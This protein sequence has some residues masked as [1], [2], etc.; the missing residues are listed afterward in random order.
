MFSHREWSR[1]RYAENPD[2]REKRRASQRA[3]RESH[4]QELSE[5]R[6][7][8]RQTDPAYREKQ[9]AREREWRSKK[10]FK[11]VYGISLEDYHV[12]SARQRGACAICKRTSH[13]RLSVDHCHATG[14]VR[15]LL[16]RKCNSG[17]AF[18]EDD[19]TRLLAAIAYLQASRREQTPQP[20]G[21]DMATDNIPFDGGKADKLMRDALLLALRRQAEDADGR[22]TDM[23]RLVADKLVDKAADGDMQAIKEI[24][25]RID[26]RSAQSTTVDEGP[27]K[28]TIRWKDQRS[29][30]TISPASSSS[31][32]TTGSSASPAS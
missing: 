19:Q 2:Y 11:Q 29:S 28:V 7:L 20:S 13:E 24:L 10:R 17:L 1:K 9:R 5:R 26:G 8:K 12:M 25:D 27:Q 3:Y 6:R 18:Y 23:L 21:G 16:C 30:S 15:G 31:A 32:S 4:K 14:K 22:K